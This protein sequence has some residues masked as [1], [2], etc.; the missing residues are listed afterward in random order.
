MKHISRVCHNCFAFSSNQKKNSAAYLKIFR[1]GVLA[2]LIAGT[3]LNRNIAVT[4][5]ASH[6]A[7][8]KTVKL[9]TTGLGT[10]IINV[11]MTP[12]ESPSARP[13]TKTIL[14]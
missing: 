11:V 10:R 2:N 7:I 5:T 6:N 14:I 12:N 13:E 4:A 8:C 1:I 9:V 3:R